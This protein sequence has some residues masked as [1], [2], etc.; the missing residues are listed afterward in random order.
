M[1]ITLSPVER[2]PA[3]VLF[4]ILR[5]LPVDDALAVFMTCT[6]LFALSRYRPFWVYANIDADFLCR[7]PKRGY[8]DYVRMSIPALQSRLLE[9]RKIFRA[10]R[11]KNAEPS[12]VQ[13]ILLENEVLH[14]TVIPWT[15]LLVI[16]EYRTVLLRD[17]CSH[18]QCTVPVT[19]ANDM[20]VFAI[21]VFWVNRLE[22][23]LLVVGLSNRGC[24]SPPRTELQIFSVDA[25]KPSAA[26]LILVEFPSVIF[27]FSLVEAHLAVIGHTRQWGYFIQSLV[28]SYKSM[29]TTFARATVRVGAQP[30]LAAS[31]F[32]IL[33]ETHFL[34]ANA[35]GIK[36]YRLSTRTLAH[37]DPRPRRIRPCWEHTYGGY[38]IL[39]RPPLGQVIVD[40]NRQTSVSICGSHHICRLSMTDQSQPR[41]RLLERTCGQ[42]VM[43]SLGGIAAGLRVGVYRRPYSVPG[44][45][46]FPLVDTTA[47]FHPFG[48][49][50]TSFISRSDGVDRGSVTYALEENDILEPGSLNVDEG[51]GRLVFLLRSHKRRGVKVVVIR[52]MLRRA[53][54]ILSLPLDVEL[55]VLRLLTLRD[56]LS[57]LMLAQTCKHLFFVSTCKSFWVYANIDADLLQRRAGRR[58]IDYSG[59]SLVALR[60]RLFRSQ[61]VFDV[62]ASQRISP[63]RVYTSSFCEDV[64][65]LLLVPWTS[66]L[67]VVGSKALRL[68]DWCSQEFRPIP[69]RRDT[70]M[71]VCNVKVSWID[72]IGRNVVAVSQ[73]N[74]GDRSEL[75]LFVVEGLSAT[76]LTTAHFPHALLDF[77]LMG[78]HLAVVGLT[79][80]QAFIESLVVSFR[81]PPSVVRKASICV[82][83]PPHLAASSF[84]ILDETHFLVASPRGI[85]VYHLSVGQST[86]DSEQA[87][88]CWHHQYRAHETLYRPPLGP[89]IVDPA[90]RHRS[91]SIYGGTYIRCLIMSSER[92]PRFRIVKRT[93]VERVPL[94][95]CLGAFGGP[96]MGLYYR[97]YPTSAAFV[98]FSLVHPATDLHPF[99]S[100]SPVSEGGSVLYRVGGGYRLENASLNIDEGEGRVVFL[101][102]SR[103]TRATELRVPLDVVLLILRLVSLQDAL[104]MFLTCRHLFLTSTYRPF[105]VYA[106]IDVDFLQR[107]PGRGRIDY[108]RTTIPDLR[109][110]VMNARRIF[111]GWRSRYTSTR[112]VCTVPLGEGVR[113]MVPI[114]WTKILILEDKN[115]VRLYEWASSASYTIP[116][117]LCAD[118]FVT[119]LKVFWVDSVGRHVLVVASSSGLSWPTICCELHLFAVDPDAVSASYMTTVRHPHLI[120]DFTLSEDHLAVIGRTAPRSYFIA[121]LAVS[122]TGGSGGV[123]HVQP[124]R[125]HAIRSCFLGAPRGSL[126]S[127]SFAILDPR[128]YLVAN[129]SGIAVYRLPERTPVSLAAR[130]IKARWI[131]RYE[132]CDVIPRPPLGPVT[133]DSASG[134]LSISF[135]TGN[136]IRRF[137]MTPGLCTRFRISERPI[138]S[139]PG[140][141]DVTSDLHI[142][143]FR[144][145][146]SLTGFETFPL[147]R[148]EDDLHPLA[149]GSRS[150]R[151]NR[152]GLVFYRLAQLDVVEPSSLHLDEAEGRIVFVQR[153]LGKPDRRK[154]KVVVLELV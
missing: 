126:A 28:L 105:W 103:M 125:F 118:G 51:E 49:T 30:S 36:V 33:N 45:A 95:M 65:Q 88:P 114:P 85:S 19:R 92:Q 67:V 39:S 42:R 38:E 100:R 71:F 23:N 151:S 41:F 57:L 144:R 48:L 80:R 6:S 101:L 9:A 117:N 77:S 93:L 121:S 78:E 3:D 109:A 96:H 56:A 90:L 43:F 127:S 27:A 149:C 21:Q 76:Y 24:S 134:E 25:D 86:T 7:R 62:W 47:D 60:A 99:G 11:T 20:F 18:E 59:L 113:R 37:K 120:S 22:R 2:L 84:S 5:L 133:L 79:A 136:F 12:S 128:H 154:P 152:Y 122:Y 140:Q 104:A 87:S 63:T 89:V 148:A 145:V 44:F 150:S 142:G 10:W 35:A 55:L 64:L 81:L 102:R 61:R 115:T 70:N 107:R 119:T 97:P 131:H 15:S 147:C 110:R 143:I 91:I 94:A 129:A 54:P 34:I 111:N 13:T 139:H 98:T 53:C 40:H 66:V 83:R 116:L 130:G 75:Q 106:N 52:L 146:Y 58:D 69:L 1:W 32:T 16:A 26:F 108:S 17:W 123:T 72:S 29:A 132:T 135:C 141:L 68:Y 137:S 138:L 4:L 31:S 124:T 153:T 8:V 46:T 50:S 14:L 74:G 112:V 82:A 73:L